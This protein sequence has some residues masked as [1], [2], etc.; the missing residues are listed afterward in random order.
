MV[1]FTNEY[2]E[3]GVFVETELVRTPVVGQAGPFTPCLVGTV[4]TY[5]KV[6]LTINRNNSNLIDVLSYNNVE[7]LFSEVATDRVIIIKDNIR[8]YKRLLDIPQNVTATLLTNQGSLADGTYFYKVAALDQND[9]STLLSSEVSETTVSPDSAITISWTAVADAVKYRVWRGTTSNGQNMYIDITTTSL[10]DD[11]SL[12]WIN[13][14]VPISSTVMG[15]FNIIKTINN[16]AAV[17]WLASGDRPNADD[18]YSVSLYITKTAPDD[19]KPKFF[20][21]SELNELYN[22]LGNIEWDNV[23]NKPKYSLPLMA[24]LAFANGAG[25]IWCVSW[26][27]SDT[28]ETLLSQIEQLKNPLPYSIVF[29]GGFQQNISSDL[30]VADVSKIK[31]HILTMS[32]I[33]EQKE[34]IAI[35]GAPINADLNANAKTNYLDT[36]AFLNHRRLMY[37]YP[38]TVEVEINNLAYKVNGSYLAA[39]LSG[40]IDSTSLSLPLTGQTIAG[41][42]NVYDIFLRQDKNKL[43]AKGVLIVEDNFRVRHALT[44]NVTDSLTRELKVTRITD[45]VSRIVRNSLIGFVS[46]PY[47]S[48]LS[49]TIGGSIKLILVQLLNAN[50]IYEYGD[51]DISRNNAEPNQLDVSFSIKPTPDTNWIYVKI[52]VQA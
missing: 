42:L 1:S 46:Q 7:L 47:S 36:V 3:P 10:T 37:C 23:N 39:A 13:G 50:V 19:Y 15:D 33:T 21:S 43:A 5:K 25:G 32:S 26:T 38:S 6:S 28:V 40:L 52:S 11:G 30:S 49:S 2:I 20:Y 44:T 51:I 45:Y 41:I 35:F 16:K 12:T 14:T 9:N 29:S 24:S 27:P 4:D 8:T 22:F 31:T 18:T 48:G 17:E 34:R